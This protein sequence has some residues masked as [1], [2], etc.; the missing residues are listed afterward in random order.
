LN[1]KLF[2]DLH[3]EFVNFRIEPTDNEKDTVVILAGDIC[4][5]KKTKLLVEF[6][7][8]TCS[9]FYK[10]I[11]VC[12]NHEFYAGDITDIDNY[13]RVATKHLTNLH[14]L[15]NETIVI[16]DVNIIGSTLWTDFD[17]ENPLLISST[18]TFFPDYDCIKIK[19]NKIKVD[20]VLREHK[21]SLHY[22]K[23]Q[24]M[25]LEGEK[26]IVVTHH[27]PLWNSVSPRFVGDFANGLF[28]SDLSNLISYYGPN[29][30][31]HGHVHDFFDYVAGD[32]R[33]MCNPRGYVTHDE[34]TGWVNTGLDF[35]L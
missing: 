17:K 5:I 24:L 35:S 11:Y 23:E 9:R 7:E 14:I 3:L 12:G 21:Y 31:C 34:Y 30:W 4:V 32:T 20:D 13:F 22:I 19:G 1:F 29:I 6:L 18:P 28:V 33:V 27:A 26:T 25:K 8:D 10:V 15:Q 2:S 16:D